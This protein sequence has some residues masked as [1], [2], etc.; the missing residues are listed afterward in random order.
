MGIRLPA[1]LFVLLTAVA[2]AQCAR[3]EQPPP[4]PAS[5]LQPIL[6]IKELMEDI[7]DPVSDDV[8]DAVSIDATPQGVVEKKPVNDDD[9]LKVERAALTLAE[10][11]NLLKM[12]RQVAP[13]DDPAHKTAPG[14]PELPPKDIEARIE[15]DRALWNRH[16]DE[17][18]TEAMRVVEIVKARQSDKL[19]EAG[20]NVD[21]ACENCHLEYWYPGDRAA[22]QRDLNSRAFTVPKPQPPKP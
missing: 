14:G 11:S 1:A 6:T 9:W 13:A 15:R 8:F 5:D 12:K 20:S 16:A 10:S 18:K 19:L 17:L 7:V 3:R 4:P 22:V 2:V 21:R